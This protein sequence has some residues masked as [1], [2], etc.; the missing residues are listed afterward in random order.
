MTRLARID[1]VH[2]L[3]LGF[4]V[5][6]AAETGTGQPRVETGTGQPRVETVYG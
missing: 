1:D 4:F 6:P 2:R 5:R 3:D